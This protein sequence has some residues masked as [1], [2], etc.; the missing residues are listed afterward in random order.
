MITAEQ[1]P[2]EVEC[3]FRKAWMDGTLTAKGALAAALNAW[4][5]IQGAWY[6]VDTPTAY[7][8]KEKSND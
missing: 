7:I 5:G 8:L 6:E 1:I 4:P 2:D 3:A